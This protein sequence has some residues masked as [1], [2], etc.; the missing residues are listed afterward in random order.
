MKEETEIKDLFSYVRKKIKFEQTKISGNFIVTEDANKRLEKVDHLMKSKIPIMLLG[1]TGTSKT[2]TILVWCDLKKQEFMENGQKANDLPGEIIRFNPSAETTIDDLFGRLISDTDSFSGFKFEMGPYLT[3]FTK[4]Y[5]F[6]LDECNLCPLFVLESIESSLDSGEY[7]PSQTA[8]D[9]TI[10]KMHKNFRLVI[11]LN[12]NTDKFASK[13]EELPER[14]KQR[15][16]S[17]LF[18]S[19]K[20]KE[21]KDI[22]KGIGKKEK[23]EN[24]KI[25]ENIAEFHY[26]WTQTEECQSS[27]QVFTIRD[28]SVTISSISNKKFI[29]SPEDAV[30]CFYGCRYE[31]K[32]RE[33]MINLLKENFP[34][35]YKNVGIPDLPS[36]FPECYHSESLKRSFY[37]SKI[38]INNGKHILFVSEEGSGLTQL[39]KWIS[40]YFSKGEDKSKD[41][42]FIFTKETTAADLLGRFIPLAGDDTNSL[43]SWRDGPLT[44]IISSGNSGVFDNLNAAQAKVTERTN[45]LLDPKEKEDDYFFEL[46]ENPEIGKIPI[47]KGFHFIATCN[48]RKIE[49]LSPALLN[50]FFVLSVDDQLTD[51]SD[52]GLEQIIE[53]IM[54][55]DIRYL[56]KIKEKREEKEKK[57]KEEKEKKEKEKE[58]KKDEKEDKKVKKEE[59]KEGKK[60]E[61]KEGKKEEEK[62]GK[63]EDEKEGKKEDE[64]EG[65]KE[66]DSKK[67]KKDEESHHHHHH[68]HHDKD[69]KKDKKEKE[70][71]KHKEKEKKDKKDKNKYSH[72]LIK[73][74]EISRE[75]IPNSL[76]KE[77]AKKYKK[78]SYTIS[79]LALLAKTAIRLY[80]CFPECEIPLLVNYCEELIGKETH[81]NIP[82][83]ISN[84]IEKILL[85]NKQKSSDEKFYYKNSK[86][87][88]E[89]MTNVTCCLIARIP[90]CLQGATGLGKTSLA[91]ALAEILR[92]DEFQPYIMYSFHLETQIDDLYGNFSF[93]DGQVVVVKGPVYQA[94]EYGKI[95][96]ADEFNLSEEAI[97]ESLSIVLESSDEG[98]RILIPGISE[99]VDYNKNFFFI[100]CQNDLSTAAR[101]R[102]PATIAKR[103]R[104]FEY[105]MPEAADIK[106]SCEEIIINEL[107]Q[108]SDD[109]ISS[110]FSKQISDFMYKINIENFPDIGIWSMRNIRKLFRRISNQQIRKED[111][112][113]IIPEIQILIYIL[114]GVQPERRKGVFL[115]LYPI[116]VE[117]FNLDKEKQDILNSFNEGEI[118]VDEETGFLYKGNCGI[119]IPDR[120]KSISYELKSL[121]ESI[122]YTL[123]CHFKEPILYCGES[124]NKTFLAQKTMPEAN[125]LN[126]NKD[127]TINTLLGSITLTN[128]LTAR[129]YYLE[130][131]L[132]ICGKI[133]EYNKLNQKLFGFFEFKKMKADKELKEK[134]LRK[135]KEKKESVDDEEQSKLRLKKLEE[136]LKKKQK[137]KKENKNKEDKKKEKKKKAEEDKIK[138]EKLEQEFNQKEESSKK[139][140]KEINEIINLFLS[141]KSGGEYPETL[142]N[143]IYHLKDKL[144]EDI[145]EISNSMFGDFTTIFK[146]GVLIENVLLQKNII[147]KNLSNLSPSIFERLNDFYNYNPKI[148]LNEDYCNTLTA[149]NKEL[150]D[151]SDGFRMIAV[152]PLDD[153]RN[154]SDAARSRLTVIYTKPYQK[155]ERKTVI[156]N[157]YPQYPAL[158]DDFLE[159][160]EANFK[161]IKFS[162][163]IKIIKFAKEIDKSNEQIS[164]IH[165]Y[166]KSFLLSAYKCL[167]PL[168]KKDKRKLLIKIMEEEIPESEKN[169]YNFLK[170]NEF[171]IE[172][173]IENK[174]PFVQDKTE[175]TLKCNETDYKIFA[176]KMN[177]EV[178]SDIA[179]V[180]TLNYM[181]EYCHLSIYSHFPLIIKGTTG[182][183]KNTAIN[184]IA[185]YL[186][187]ELIE[188]SLSNSTTLE[189]LF[190]KEI[191]I[192]EGDKIKFLTIRSKLLDAIE[193]KEQKNVIIYLKNI[194]QAS[195][196]ILEALIP[197][198][199]K[200]RKQILISTG[201][202]D[203]GIYNLIA[204]FDQSSKGAS[205]DMLPEAIKLNSILCNVPDYSKKEFELIADMMFN[206]KS[207]VNEKKFYVNDFIKMLNFTN[208]NQLK[209]LFSLNDFRKFILFR[210]NDENNIIGYKNLVKL[211]LA[212]KFSSAVN[213]EKASECLEYNK[214]EFWPIFYYDCE[215]A[216]NEEESEDDEDIDF[217]FCVGGIKYKLRDIIREE[218][219]NEI[220]K[221][222]LSFTLSQREAAIFLLLAVKANIICIING[223]SGSGKGYLIRTFAEACGEKLVNIDLNNDSG[224]SVI[225][226]QITPKSKLLQE[227]IDD[228]KKIFNKVIEIPELS[229][230]ILEN[231]TLNSPNTW[232]PNN[233]RKIL[234]TIKSYPKEILDEHEN[235]IT[236]LKNKIVSELSFIKHLVNEDSPFIKAMIEGS[237]VN[238]DGIEKAQ[239]ELPE[240][241]LSLCDPINPYLNLFEKGSNYFYSR[242]A[243][244]PKFRIHENFRLFM[245]YNSLDVDP[246]KKLGEGFLNKNVVFSLF[247]NDESNISSGL[248]LSGLFKQN[249]LFGKNATEM[250]ARFANVHQY[251]KNL[252]KTEIDK[253]AGKKQFSGRT[254]NFVFNSLNNRD[255]L[256]EQII[257]AIEDC[258]S[259]SYVNPEKLKGD[260]LKKFCEQPSVE[261]KNNINKNENEA[262]QKYSEINEVL[263][264]LTKTDTKLDF[265]LFVSLI[266]SCEYK[267]LKQL[268]TKISETQNKIIEVKKDI[269][270]LLQ[271]IQNLIDEFIR[272]DNITPKLKESFKVKQISKPSMSNENF[273]KYAQ[274]KYFLL[275]ALLKNDFNFAISYKN[276]NDY[277]K[278][279]NNENYKKIIFYELT[280]NN[281][282]PNDLLNQALSIIYS[283]PELNES[284]GYKKDNED[285]KSKKKVPYKE[286]YE[287][288]SSK[289]SKS[290]VSSKSN[291]S[292]SGAKSESRSISKKS[293]DG[294]VSSKSR[295]KSKSKSSKSGSE[296]ASSKSKNKSRS[297][298]NKSSKSSKSSQSKISD[299]K[300]D[301]KS[302]HSNENKEGKD[303]EKKEFEEMELKKE[304]FKGEFKEVNINDDK[305]E[306]NIKIE[307]VK[308]IDINNLNIKGLQKDLL[309]I[310][311]KIISH[312]IITNRSDYKEEEKN[313]ILEDPTLK[314]IISFFLNLEEIIKDKYFIKC[315]NDDNIEELLEKIDLKDKNN[316]E[317][318][319]ERLD[320]LKKLKFENHDKTDYSIIY[321]YID[322]W[323]ET[324]NEFYNKKLI[325]S[326]YKKQNQKEKAEI[327]EK[328]NKLKNELQ[329]ELREESKEYI[330]KLN[331]IGLDKAKFEEAEKTMKKLIEAKKSEKKEEKN[332]ISV[333]PP[334]KTKIF[335]NYTDFQKVLEILINYSKIMELVD[336]L[337]DESKWYSVYLKLE[338]FKYKKDLDE[339]FD[340]IINNLL[341]SIWKNLSQPDKKNEI[342]SDFKNQ[343]RS[344]IL[345]S[346]YNISPNYINMNSIRNELNRFIKGDYSTEQDKFWASGHIDYVLPSFTLLIPELNAKDLIPLFS[347]EKTVEAEK[348]GEKIESTKEII[349]GL[350]FSSGLSST[351]AKTFF[352]EVIKLKEG[353]YESYIELLDKIFDLFN[354]IILKNMPIIKEEKEEN[355]EKEKDEEKE[356][357]EEKEKDIE[358]EKEEKEIKKKEE[359]FRYNL[360]KKIMKEN[361][362]HIYNFVF[363]FL[364]NLYKYLPDKHEPIIDISYKDIFFVNEP[365]WLKNF[366]K[367][368]SQYP[369][370]I[371]FLLDNR[372]NYTEK[373]L[374]DYL[375]S[376]EKSNNKFPIFIHFLRIFGDNSYMEYNENKNKFICGEIIQ[377]SLVRNILKRL[378]TNLCSNLNWLMLLNDKI[379][380]PKDLY[381]PRIEYF[382][383][384]LNFLSQISIISEESKKIFSSVIDNLVD[385]LLDIIFENKIDEFF[386]TNIFN[387]KGEVNEN[388]KYFCK[389]TSLVE[390]IALS[391]NKEDFKIFPKYFEERIQNLQKLFNKYYSS[392]KNNLYTNII[393]TL[394]KEIE[395]NYKMEKEKD[396]MDRK[397]KKEEKLMKFNTNI[398][399]YNDEFNKLNK[400]L[401]EDK[402]N[403]EE[404]NKAST[405][406][407]TIPFENEEKKKIFSDKKDEIEIFEYKIENPN[408]VE[409]L[410]LERKDIILHE[411]KQ[412]FYAFSNNHLYL[413]LKNKSGQTQLTGKK[414]TIKNLD[415]EQVNK[416]KELYQEEMGKLKIDDTLEQPTLEL[417]DANINQDLE[418]DNLFKNMKNFFAN[419]RKLI[420]NL[421]EH[422]DNVNLLQG[423]KED[424][425]NLLKDIKEINMLRPRLKD[426][427]LDE[428][429]RKCIEFG[430]FKDNVMK[431]LESL[432]NTYKSYENIINKTDDNKKIIPKEFNIMKLD[433]IK[434]TEKKIG[435]KAGFDTS[436]LNISTPYLSLSTDN[437]LQFC[438]KTY[439]QEINSIIP[440]LYYGEKIKF[441]IISFVDKNVKSSFIF[442][443]ENLITKQLSVN[444]ITKHNEPIIIKFEIPYDQVIEE[445]ENDK[446]TGQLN[447]EIVEESDTNLL[448]PFNFKFEFIPLNVIF[449]SNYN[450]FFSKEN[451]LKYAF[452]NSPLNLELFLSFRFEKSILPFDKWKNNY[453]IEKLEGNDVEEEPKLIFNEDDQKFLVSFSKIE[454]KLDGKKLN[455]KIKFYI[456]KNLTIPIVISTTFHDKRFVF[457]S[458]NEVKNCLDY[459]KFHIYLYEEVFEQ[460]ITFRVEYEDD[461]PHQITVSHINIPCSSYMSLNYLDGN[462]LKFEKGVT[463]RIKFI[464]NKR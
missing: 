274:G 371:Y 53:I 283:Y 126:I 311:N 317:E 424:T 75:E 368:Y 223:P 227:E 452:E 87:L 442:N 144:L 49:E 153:I 463:F 180:N 134:Q 213:I 41:F 171:D 100:A 427:A 86:N 76:I 189:D 174:N 450:F 262:E 17:M 81:L 342:I 121:W 254:L 399:N 341:N 390:E 39:A 179:F 250:A 94:V 152:I 158:F 67:S 338:K 275:Y 83:N 50:R 310:V 335:S 433:N 156:R 46:P 40:D 360:I 436:D 231:I 199:D 246:N 73:P 133:N 154:F 247:E 453:S 186:G 104:L 21:L 31:K 20:G 210:Q 204:T 373:K 402:K 417:N 122:F 226:G 304:D 324:Y 37:Y 259:V 23:Y 10:Y 57:E 351:N 66:K 319:L 90:V 309:I 408:E 430:N 255:E 429:N 99:S 394:N 214:E 448:I 216:K 260:L 117:C 251:A 175:S 300:E 43:I 201:T 237:W 420:N 451:N 389:I 220:E 287:S 47:N 297:K 92:N 148:T 344:C 72:E 299:L 51:L 318:L 65:K 459:N 110:I 320:E 432:L 205:F 42:V 374:I 271:I 196:N 30:F 190:S 112:I 24:E 232:K 22:A 264:N 219:R 194:E 8:E 354:D 377:S 60:E 125:V 27:P 367:K 303:E 364:E 218:K 111:Y 245:T 197:V 325:Q 28:L 298:S 381:N 151:F 302:I 249:N 419:F 343:L 225:T 428:I 281:E 115:Q 352:K 383:N 64:N 409:K 146:A 143:I 323:Y 145:L 395:N 363:E 101:K 267:Y 305:E 3:A 350:F 183:G 33:A 410:E 208:E 454:N 235:I 272:R 356:K 437:K 455:A 443:E 256:K 393:D 236:E 95:L 139:F 11:T 406:I 38:A 206:G 291:K 116:L 333:F 370:I 332:Y 1:P 70:D 168:L 212:H 135:E 58:K 123:F 382:H 284:I 191:P 18:D 150:H 407:K 34:L 109:S 132:K 413:S 178:G 129:Q 59:E 331:F 166:E 19:F 396:L 321:K 263:E 82:I 327:E 193:N 229:D 294:S 280:E 118:K 164:Q 460:L 74:K 77:I 306:I 182:S 415:M 91:R 401:S 278:E 187:F 438:L 96:I 26:A 162:I 421:N 54:A 289:S 238:L 426:F 425:Q 308:H 461:N 248:V 290:S 286:N 441:N 63:K 307:K 273:L 167:L 128:S 376:L 215:E 269:Y 261:L 29:T 14:F 328:L 378:E 78:H 276:I 366:N 56:E 88:L 337:T 295:S 379:N 149:E 329:R 85:K 423:Y 416:I 147:L 169:K 120:Y 398:N 108:D 365:N 202:I 270:S 386:G 285:I 361:P 388:Y 241:I 114:G 385:K 412:Y 257:S 358:K 7:T 207:F 418:S 411:Y 13:R 177:N 127:T 334:I 209:E 141:R 400:L 268:K 5:V 353:E 185:K 228:L 336:G 355:K 414:I 314:I 113:N 15:F 211:L 312:I 392:N 79:R 36:D 198:F 69:D 357:N 440:A 52:E 192:Q 203:K 103:I 347:L 253:F 458:L 165:S 25:V 9:K 404:V 444:Q 4:G 326:Y 222:F 159:K 391:K 380:I 89:L 252:S 160:F 142:R 176:P 93:Q 68:H 296:S 348:G 279:A 316:S 45:G 434:L 32:G 172:S 105:P 161:G 80:V 315:I 155:D 6:L 439:N 369:N 173:N 240:R 266:G 97:L 375:S 140:E 200:S 98:T 16:N 431:D 137:E 119:K 372:E 234:E 403:F 124:G 71:I 293:K 217:F 447:F 61:E 349:K 55:K 446:I 346:L 181:L 157:L 184:Y 130:L 422:I 288:R 339:S 84:I 313:K 464:F 62:E 301:E 330:N 239:P 405:T 170:Y 462:I 282:K 243:T 136:K 292:K 107:N 242:N 322:E 131:I 265:N 359:D 12:P 397:N 387:E 224:V 384:Y 244:D 230:I 102:H 345:L 163:L 188:F 138:K 456:T 445:E 340:L 44:K 362:E 258:Y 233:F 449:E 435:F 35:L 2:K 221:K 48:I 106:A 277:L 457:A 195:A